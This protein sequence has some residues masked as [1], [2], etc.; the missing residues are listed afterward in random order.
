LDDF[1]ARAG[2]PAKNGFAVL[3]RLQAELKR[4]VQDATVAVFPPP[5]VSGIGTAGGY[6]VM[7]EDRGGLGTQALQQ[8]TDALVGRL[9]QTPGAGTA[10][11]SFRAN[12]PQ[13]YADVDRTKCK[14]LGVSL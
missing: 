2:D 9:N 12:T 10:F 6:R 3:V 8:A 11:T 1:D 13:L 14:Q 5:P 7:V 4:R